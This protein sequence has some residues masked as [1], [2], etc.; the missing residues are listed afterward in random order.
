MGLVA[1]IVPA[2]SVLEA[3]RRWAEEMMLC[4]PASLA[5]TK[6]VVCSMDGSSIEQSM[7]DMLTI[8][9]VRDLF[10]GPDAL[11]GVAAFAEKRAP[12]WSDLV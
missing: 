12:R 8:P 6:A 9:V 11:E 7:L 10:T 4:S 2:A 5:A 3:A 1:E